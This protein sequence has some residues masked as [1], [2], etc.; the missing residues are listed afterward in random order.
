MGERQTE[1]ERLKAKYRAAYPDVEA[2]MKVFWEAHRYY[3]EA[4]EAL[5]P[6][7]V[8]VDGDTSTPPVLE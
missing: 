4:C 3:R 5:Q 2:T 8:T 1:L 6:R 7:C